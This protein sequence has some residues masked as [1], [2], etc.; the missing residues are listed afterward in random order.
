MPG[1]HPFLWFDTQALEAAEFYV[2]VFPNSRINDV[3]RY[4][5]AGPGEPGQVMT[6]DF[7]L[8]GK[9]FTALN[10]GTDLYDFNLGVSFVVD[11]ASPAE[12]DHYWDAL[13][14]GGKENACGWLQDRY[15][16][17][18]QIVPVGLPALV[19]D[20]DP[21]R[22]K[23][24]ATAMFGTTKLDF[25]AMAAAA[26]EAGV[27]GRVA[28]SRWIDA[29]AD[30]I[31]E[32]LTDPARHPDIDGSGMLRSAEPQTLTAV[33]DEFRVKM[34]NDRMGNYLMANTV[35]EYVE[36][37]R[38]MWDPRMVETERANP[39]ADSDDGTNGPGGHRWGYSL[40]PTGPGHTLVT[41]V[42]DCSR[43][44]EWLKTAT[45]H[46]EE[47]R[48]AMTATLDKLAATDFS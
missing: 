9:R 19:G 31:F 35:V 20:P 44:P 41:E 47:W 30:A 27:K 22:A 45:H 46:G 24:A 14:D 37:R 28:M 34:H 15:G 32:L 33:G 26:E 38:L 16:L 6:V 39:D 4:S 5:D 3:A 12:L 10:G 43:S 18:W 11:C 2:S 21:A 13:L 23:A 36:G 1:I 17:A 42:F 8:D 7:E 48:P 25:P 40:L 29:P